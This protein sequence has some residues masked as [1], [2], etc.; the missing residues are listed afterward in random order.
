MGHDD[1]KMVTGQNHNFYCIYNRFY[2]SL[3]IELVSLLVF[4]SLFASLYLANF[5]YNQHFSSEIAPF[6]KSFTV[7]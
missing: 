6:S 1:L 2:K 5:S 4:V 7:V 3:E